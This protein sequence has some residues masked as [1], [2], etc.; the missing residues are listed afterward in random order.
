M[1]ALPAGAAFLPFLPSRIGATL[2]LQQLQMDRPA[3]WLQPTNAP[4]E[5]QILSLV[6]LK[7]SFD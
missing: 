4:H 6:Q 1:T 3:S 5:D 7:I 2:H